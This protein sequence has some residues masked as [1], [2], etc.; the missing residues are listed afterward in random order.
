MLHPIFWIDELLRLVID[1]LVEISPPA[2]VSFALTCRSFEEPTLSSLWKRQ[3]SLYDLLRVLPDCTLLE[4]DDFLV[5]LVSHCRVFANLIRFDP[6]WTSPSIPPGNRG[7]SFNR[8]L[9][10]AAP[11]CLFDA[12]IGPRS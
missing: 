2:A 10:Q 6:H 12:W 4:D 5:V 3:H 11:I 8:G 1:K 7:R 9:G